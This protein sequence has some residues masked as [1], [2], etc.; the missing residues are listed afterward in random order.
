[1]IAHPPSAEDYR[2]FAQVG[3]SM[4]SQGIWDHAEVQKIRDSAPPE[5]KELYEMGN[6][7]SN[8]DRSKNPYPNRF[9]PEHIFP[10][11]RAFIEKWWDTCV[12]QNSK[13]CDVS[14]KF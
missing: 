9:L 10:G 2:G 4:V 7:Y 14:A 13:F 11:F 5:Q 1:M 8:D 6:P 12:D 3:L